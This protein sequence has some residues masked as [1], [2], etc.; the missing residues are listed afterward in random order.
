MVRKKW[1]KYIKTSSDTVA[2]VHVTQTKCFFFP[3]LFAESC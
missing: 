1:N 2:Q 3:I